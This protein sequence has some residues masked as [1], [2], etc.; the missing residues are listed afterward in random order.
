MGN[1]RFHG[2]MTEK[3]ILTVDQIFYALERYWYCS[4]I[5]WIERSY[6]IVR[7]HQFFS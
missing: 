6:V 1:V 2:K 7:V 4:G 3:A 5:K